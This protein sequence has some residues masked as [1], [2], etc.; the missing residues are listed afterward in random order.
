M[1]NRHQ[2]GIAYELLFKVSSTYFSLV[3]LFFCCLFLLIWST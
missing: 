3:M 1:V 2:R